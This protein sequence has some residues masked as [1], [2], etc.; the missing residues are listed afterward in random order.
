MDKYSPDGATR[1]TVKTPNAARQA[2]IRRP[3]RYV[4]TLSI[5]GAIVAL[6]IVFLLVHGL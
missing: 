6:A 4:L 5:L 2:E 3:M 1:R